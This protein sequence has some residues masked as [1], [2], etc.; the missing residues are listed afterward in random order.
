M[1]A[2]LDNPLTTRGTSRWSLIAHDGGDVIPL[3][4]LPC[5]VGRHPGAAVRV[6]HPTVSL[7]HAEFRRQGEGLVIADLSSR[8]GTFVNGKRVLQ[9]AALVH[10]DLVQFG[11][12]VFR[13]QGQ[14]S[15]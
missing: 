1:E 7:T 5:Q 3:R 13:V 14:A 11:G 15:Q 4:T 8:N 12:A 2:L 10:D 9:S 6:I